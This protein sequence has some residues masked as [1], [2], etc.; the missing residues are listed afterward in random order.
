MK[1]R[2]RHK[3]K[4]A[5]PAGAVCR[6][7]HT[8]LEGPYCCQCGQSYTA[9]SEQ[10]I[11]KLVGDFLGNAFAFDGKVP[12]T[13]AALFWRPGRLSRDYREGHIVRYTSPMQLFWMAV[14]IL[15]A[16]AAAGQSVAEERGELLTQI[17]VGTQVDERE[18]DQSSRVTGRQ[19]TE[20]LL[21]WGPYI[22]VALIP[23]F[24]LLLRL[25][26]WRRRIYYMYHLVFALHFH[27]F[28]LLLFAFAQGLGLLVLVQSLNF[29]LP[30]TSFFGSL[31]FVMPP[32]YLA[33]ASHRFYAP[34]TRWRAVWR[35]GLLMLIYGAIMIV[36]LAAIAFLLSHNNLKG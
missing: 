22:A 8:P 23:V 36:V 24:A 32:V 10:P 33:I 14:I 30:A 13:L 27:S 28:F 20:A 29:F 26:Y 9:G 25:F 18:D 12:R 15:V 34:L 3:E 1:L 11:A 7:C 31:S 6:N 19:L 2:F 5:P 17:S 16:V 21:T 4:P 35:S